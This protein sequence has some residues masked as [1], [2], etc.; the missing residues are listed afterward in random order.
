M[1]ARHTF[2]P[3]L[4]FGCRSCGE[5]RPEAFPATY[6]TIC[7]RCRSAREAARLREKARGAHAAQ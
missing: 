1:P 5:R 7:S 2:G 3:R 6:K 4:S